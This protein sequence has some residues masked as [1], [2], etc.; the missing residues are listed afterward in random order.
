MDASRPGKPKAG[1]VVDAL[2]EV[3]VL[4]GSGEAAIG[5]VVEHINTDDY[6]T[7]IAPAF[8]RHIGFAVPDKTNVVGALCPTLLPAKTSAQPLLRLRMRASAAVGVRSSFSA[9]RQRGR[10]KRTL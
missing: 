8:I 6:L 4:S 5:G 1:S 2:A 10:A 7:F 3:S 9:R